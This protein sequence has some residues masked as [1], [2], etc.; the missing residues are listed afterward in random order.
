MPTFLNDSKEVKISGFRLKMERKWNISVPL[1][2]LKRD[3]DNGNSII[4]RLND[5]RLFLLNLK[6]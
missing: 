3:S 4:K 2:Q 1:C 5:C 6:S